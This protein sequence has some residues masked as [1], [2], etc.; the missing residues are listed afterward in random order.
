M[1]VWVERVEQE[2]EEAV[3]PRLRHLDPHR[4]EALT[5]DADR[6]RAGGEALDAPERRCLPAHRDGEAEAGRR[7][8]R[9]ALELPLGRQAV[10][11]RVQLD[12]GRPFRVEAQ[13]LLRPRLGRVEAVLPG[14]VREAGRAGVDRPGRYEP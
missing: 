12:G 10:E 13:E 3:V 2:Q 9:P 4:A 5:E 8:F 14:R 11:G 6:L 1:D 7:R